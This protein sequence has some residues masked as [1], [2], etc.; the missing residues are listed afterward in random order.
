MEFSDY[1]S[2]VDFEKI[3]IGTEYQD[4]QIGDCI[5]INPSSIDGIDLAFFSV[6]EDRG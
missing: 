6:S 2:P 4:N 1:F 5:R 3:S